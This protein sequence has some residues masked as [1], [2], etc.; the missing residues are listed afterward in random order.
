MNNLLV[1]RWLQATWILV[2]LL[3]VSAGMNL[4]H[5]QNSAGA[6]QGTVVDQSGRAIPGANVAAISSTRVVLKAISGAEGKFEISGVP[7]GSYTVQASAPGFS[8]VNKSVNVTAGGAIS[9]P[10]SLNIASVS[11]EV[12]VEAEADTS[13]AAELSPVKSVLDAG[14]ARTEITSNYVSQFT[15]P[16]TDFSDLTQAAPG[17][18]SWSTNGI[19]NGQAKTFFRGFKD[20]MYSMTWDG[21]PFQDSNDPTHH[22]W[23]YVPAAAIGYVDFDRSPG[24]S[25][26]M[27]PSN[28]AGAIH[29]F[30][31]RLNDASNFQASE[32]YGSFNTNNFLGQYNSGAFLNGKAHFWLEGH[33]Q[34]SDGY[35]MF[36]YQQRTAATA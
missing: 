7:A 10:L 36:N 8:T 21:V 20:G 18:V 26:D 4:L 6:I 34:T 1:R 14:S 30:S 17:T 24:T 13:L 28:F 32:S 16:V 33:H 29:Y 27:G 11:Q 35:Q 9:V 31:P 22:S 12:T 19:G 25:S 2:C 5:A 3:F 23:A 15:T